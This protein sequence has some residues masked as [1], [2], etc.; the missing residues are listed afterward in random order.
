MGRIGGIPGF[1]RK[2][3]RFGK[4]LNPGTV[5]KERKSTHTELSVYVGVWA[6]V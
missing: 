6:D 1:L 5:P 3:N 2:K 4:L